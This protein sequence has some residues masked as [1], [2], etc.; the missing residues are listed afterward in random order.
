MLREKYINLTKDK[1]SVNIEL[2]PGEIN[3]DGF[4]GIDVVD[5]KAT[6]IVHNIE[7]GL[8]FIPD[9]DVDNYYSNHVLEHINNYENL[10]LE[11]HR[12]LKKDGKA[13]MIV[14]HFTNSY[15]YSDYTHK[16]SFGLFSFD[17]FCDEK[18]QLRTKVPNF[19]T[20]I[21]FKI[22]K[23]ELRFGSKFL[24]FHWGLQVFKKIV[25][26]NDFTKEFYEVSLSNYIR[27]NEVRFIISPVK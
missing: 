10:I 1:T 3:K 11:I 27:C 21:R 13:E 16:R 18:Y 22:L 6:D 20:S 7:D 23:R 2:G 9:N 25:N 8:A 26:L 15:F 24:F 12:T 14:P 17:Y 19:Y 4:L 5:L